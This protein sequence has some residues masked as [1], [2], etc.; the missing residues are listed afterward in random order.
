M[1]QSFLEAAT[2]PEQYDL[3]EVDWRADGNREHFT[4]RMILEAILP[5]IGDV[6]GKDV[7][8]IGAGQGWLC[9]EL[10]E[11]GARTV[12]IEPSLQNVSAAHEQFRE[13]DFREW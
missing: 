1:S 13:L 5:H 6:Q 8:D 11:L 2:N 7:L 3:G 9:H 12:G 4:R 10:T